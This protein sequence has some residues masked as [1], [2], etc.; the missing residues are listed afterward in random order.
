MKTSI[1]LYI[2]AFFVISILSFFYIA[3][4]GDDE[5]YGGAVTKRVGW[6]AADESSRFDLTAVMP[7]NLQGKAEVVRYRS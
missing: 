5:D 3:N 4:L 1:Y 6:T 2:S 7:T